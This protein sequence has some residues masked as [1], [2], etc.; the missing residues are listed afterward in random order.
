[1][2]LHYT[3]SGIITPIGVDDTRGCA[4]Q[5]WPP[6]DEH[7]YS[8]NV[9]AWNQLIVKQKFCA[10]SWLI[11]EINDNKYWCPLSVK[12]LH[13][14]IILKLLCLWLR[15]SLIYINIIQRDAT[16]SSIFIILQ[17]HSTCFRCQP[18]PSS[19]VHKTV[20]TASGIWHISCA[21]TYLQRGQLGHV[22]EAL[23]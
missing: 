21:A 22:G 4:M 11:T 16:Q 2:W 20:T 15:A 1:M 8:E 9:E 5:F 6:D 12:F 3:A 7:M 13:Q 18:H 14:L 10:S 23:I 19:G 17:V